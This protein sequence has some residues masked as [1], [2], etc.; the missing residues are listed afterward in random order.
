MAENFLKKAFLKV[1]HDLLAERN[2]KSLQSLY[3]YYTLLKIKDVIKEK[4]EEGIIYVYLNINL[5]KNE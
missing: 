3:N 5:E 4:E 2:I 1:L